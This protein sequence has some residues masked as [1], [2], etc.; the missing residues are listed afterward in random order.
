MLGMLLF[1]VYV[2]IFVDTITMHQWLQSMNCIILFL[3]E[4]ILC[5][6]SNLWIACNLPTFRLPDF[7][8]WLRKIYFSFT[9]NFCFHTEQTSLSFFLSFSFFLFLSL[10][11]TAT[12]KKT[13]IIIFAVT[14]LVWIFFFSKKV[15]HESVLLWQFY[16]VF[17]SKY[18]FYDTLL[19]T[20][21]SR[22][23]IAFK[24][25]TVFH[26]FLSMR[27]VQILGHPTLFFFFF[28][29]DEQLNYERKED[30]LFFFLFY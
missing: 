6:D 25:A 22:M 23:P 8:I 20:L 17:C 14:E 19:R 9:L 16:H 12:L 18:L 3:N 26:Y 11:F 15:L 29:R 4:M 5:Y 24:K 21:L 2:Y 28:V 7:I 30:I 27:T 13:I 1:I 10:S